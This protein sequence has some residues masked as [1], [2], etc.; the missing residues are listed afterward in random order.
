M[1]VA[2]VVEQAWDPAS[3]EVLAG[4][5]AIDWSRAAPEPSHGSLDAL[6]LA[7]GLGET[8]VFGLGPSPVEELLR[9]CLA[10]G[11]A[12]AAV[13]SDVDSLAEA[14]RT[15]A[16]DVVLAPHRSGDQGAGP[17]AGLLAGLLDLPQATAVES[18]RVLDGEAIVVRRLDRGE[19]EELAVPLPAVIAVEPGVA[20]PRGVSP[21]A[22]LAAR[23]TPVGAVPAVPGVVPRPLFVGHRAPRPGPPR[24]AAPDGALPAEA[25]IASVVGTASGGPLR[26]LAG[27]PPYQ[28]AERIVRLLRERGYLPT[29][30]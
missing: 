8:H 9:G 18:L 3:I 27:G 26:E 21:A 20:R 10:A 23:S 15:G 30:K 1:R 6:E 7:L 22:L 5:G 11:A 4:D 25:R 14:L 28:V 17:V 13:A 2:A 12:A 29:T 16:F 19:R 24:M